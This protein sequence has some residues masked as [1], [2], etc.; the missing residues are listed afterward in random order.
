MKPVDDDHQR[1]VER[2]ENLIRSF[3]RR[4]PYGPG[5]EETE[6]LLQEARLKL[7]QVLENGRDIEYLAAYIRKIVDSIVMDHLQKLIRERTLLAAAAW[8]GRPE[9]QDSRKREDDRRRELVEEV[10]AELGALV[11]SRRTVLQMTLAGY[12]L[13][14]IAATKNWTRKKTYALYERGLKDLKHIFGNEGRRS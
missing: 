1:T 9:S 6:D 12:S 5:P 14:E 3:L 4:H 11:G 10:Q 8:R 7:W 2:F 13:G